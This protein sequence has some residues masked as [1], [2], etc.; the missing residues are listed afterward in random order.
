MRNFSYICK[1]FKLYT[2]M[3]YKEIIYIV[4]DLCKQF[5]DDT[6]LNEDHILFLLKKYRG[7][8][9]Q[10]YLKIKTN[11]PNSNYQTIKL[12]INETDKSS[13][14]YEGAQMCSDEIVPAIISIGNPSVYCPGYYSN[15]NKYTETVS[16]LTG[17]LNLISRE[18]MRYVGHGPIKN[19]VYCSVGD[20]GNLY[21]KVHDSQ[22]NNL[23]QIT[24]GIVYMTAIFEDVVLASELDGKDTDLLDKEFPLESRLVPDLIQATVKDILGASYRPKDD[25]NDANDDLAR[26]AYF[27]SKN[28]KS[29]LAKQLDGTE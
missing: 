26:L 5:S 14:N 10:Q 9:L 29:D 17:Q 28:V 15:E 25:I 21:I 6:T 1:R 18:R 11:V 20:T 12:T 3:K 13:Q 22:I 24:N 19:Q 16:L 27:L 2:V 8:L 4:N 7:A 23:P